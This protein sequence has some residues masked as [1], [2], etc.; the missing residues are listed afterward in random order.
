MRDSRTRF[1]D[2]LGSWG[3]S[4]THLLSP[5]TRVPSRNSVN[6]TFHAVST[7][8]GPRWAFQDV[9][10]GGPADRAGIKSGDI[11]LAVDDK[12]VLPP[13]TPSFLMNSRSEV[14]VIHRNGSARK[15]NVEVSTPHPKYSE[16]PYSEPQN[17][18]ASVVDDR[19]GYLKVAMFPGIIGVDF[20][21]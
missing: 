12:E 18:V 20:A 15:V 17:V 10:P 11:L 14:A 21:H 2:L 7:E 4:H 16:C 1:N 3:T 8:L 6:A 5:R 19:I 9:Q 13:R